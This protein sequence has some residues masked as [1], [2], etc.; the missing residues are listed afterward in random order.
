MEGSRCLS[1]NLPTDVPQE[2]NQQQHTGY[3]QKTSWKARA[4][5]VERTDN[6]IVS[7]VH[8]LSPSTAAYN[9]KP[10]Y[11]QKVARDLHLAMAQGILV[12]LKFSFCD[13]RTFSTKQNLSWSSWIHE[14]KE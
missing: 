6:N 2:L 4:F 8:Q 7:P 14:I 13:T 11:K 10:Q 3:Y 5:Q 12:I 9:N 1:S